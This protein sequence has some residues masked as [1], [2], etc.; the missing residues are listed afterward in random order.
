M[1]I[2][3]A[4]AALLEK[5]ESPS[6]SSRFMSGSINFATLMPMRAVP[7]KQIWLLGMNDDAYPRKR[8]FNDFD[9][10]SQDY[11]PGDRSR[12]DDDRYLF[13]EA[14]LSARDKLVISWHGRS[15]KD[16]SEQPP[17]VLVSQLR[18]YL[19][20]AWPQ[21]NLLPRSTL[22]YPLQ[23][24]SEV[25]FQ[26][27]SR[28]FTYAHEWAEQHQISPAQQAT[29]LPLW[30][31]ERALNRADLVNCLKSPIDS[32]YQQ[33]LLIAKPRDAAEVPS[34]ENF[35]LDGLQ[36]WQL[37]NQ[38]ISQ[39]FS[40]QALDRQIAV[41]E[42]ADNLQ[43]QFTT[44]QRDG[45]L[46]SGIAGQIQSLPHT[47]EL[48]ELYE[49]WQQL[50]SQHLTA[51]MPVTYAAAHHVSQQANDS[52]AVE[53]ALPQL[54]INH[55]QKKAQQVLVQ[56]STAIKGKDLKWRNLADAWVQ[57]LV[58]HLYSQMPVDT[59]LL[60]PQGRLHYQ[61]LTAQQAEHFFEQL[62]QF[63]WQAMHEPLPLSLQLGM[64]LI[65]PKAASESALDTAYGKDLAYGSQY[66]QRHFA[67]RQDLDTE[68]CTKLASAVYEPWQ[69]CVE[70][71]S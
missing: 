38:V 23:P 37:H 32:L 49:T 24:F 52:L 1:A 42:A 19:A 18:D 44:W 39:Q 61:P 48:V 51:V 67:S 68:L 58:A 66:L 4:Q 2:E 36:T 27:D 31:P 30:K 40:Q 71:F 46:L 22:Q 6:L 69:S 13:L 11:R 70:T 33:R 7:F 17:S 5:L 43:Q 56:A 47:E 50:R 9:L 25:L 54:A 41:S 53:I 45:T 21:Q 16:D 28:Y 12:R 64:K 62:L 20:K 60:T 35:T 63:W 55:H 65:Q 15:I 34:I 14:L 10:I 57:H 26:Q 8:S 3:L 59:Y 29:K